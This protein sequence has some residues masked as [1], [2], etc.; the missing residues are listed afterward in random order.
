MFDVGEEGEEVGNDDK[1]EVVE[2]KGEAKVANRY[3]RRNEVPYDYYYYSNG[4]V[5]VEP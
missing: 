5:K 2:W 1:H 4:F 3:F